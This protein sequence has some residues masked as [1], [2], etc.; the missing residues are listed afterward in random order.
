MQKW[1]SREK[2]S[3]QQ[4]RNSSEIKLAGSDHMGYTLPETTSSRL[5]IGRAIYP[6]K[7]RRTSSNHQGFQVRKSEF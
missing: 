4:C 7:E 3:R 5:N 6:Q 1:M 2:P